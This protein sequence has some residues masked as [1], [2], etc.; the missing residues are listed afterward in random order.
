[1]VSPNH[2]TELLIAWRGGDP[3]AFEQLVPIVYN[4]LRHL[5]HGYMRGENVG[6]AL[7]TTELVHE[8]YLRMVDLEIDWQDRHHFFALAAR[9]MRRILVD[10][11][12]R[13][14]AEKR[15]GDRIQVD[16]EHV[17]LSAGPAA[18][19]LALN[20]ALESLAQFDERKSQILELRFFAG[21][22]I[23]E[24]ASALSLS[25]ATVERDYKMAKAWLAREMKSA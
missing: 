19:L 5:A 25:H 21:L 14:R 13:Q 10:F 3:D 1:M 24:T 20:D 8:A 23:Q 17:G 9:Q 22:T 11:A 7:Q 15:G 12:R 2:V 18:D 4:E 6:H 16:L